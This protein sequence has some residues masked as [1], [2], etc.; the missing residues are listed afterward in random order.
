MNKPVILIMFDGGEKKSRYESVSDLYTSDYYKKVVSFSVAFEAKN[1][2]SLKDY[3]NQ[4]LRDPD[5]L[6][7]QQEKFKQ[8]FCHLVDGKSGKRLF[9]LIYDTTK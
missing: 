6:R 9:D 2:S 5:S 4:C 8:Y 7:A 1:V 3:I